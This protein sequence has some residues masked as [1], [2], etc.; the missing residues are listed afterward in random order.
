MSPSLLLASRLFLRSSIIGSTRFQITD[1]NQ[2][3]PSYLGTL[4]TII[5]FIVST[6]NSCQGTQM[7]TENIVD[8]NQG[9]VYSTHKYYK[10]QGPTT[11]VYVKTFPLC[12]ETEIKCSVLLPSHPTKLSWHPLYGVFL[13]YG[14]I[15][16]LCSPGQSK[17]IK[18]AANMAIQFL[19]LVTVP[20][21]ME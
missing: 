15:N 13:P 3:T 20:V 6:N 4:T 8:P 14:I 7:S 11:L 21:G 5:G 2:S 19:E 9:A 17:A 1:S 10:Y 16:L 12:L 18:L